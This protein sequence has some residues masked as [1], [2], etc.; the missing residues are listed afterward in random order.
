VTA[1]AATTRKRHTVRGAIFGFLFGLF[2][3]LDLFLF[4]VVPSDSIVITVLALGGLVL[5]IL[6]GRTTPFG[7]KAPATTAGPAGPP[8]A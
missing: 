3:G 6:I 5:G 4:G 2:V 1:P 8:A 7:R